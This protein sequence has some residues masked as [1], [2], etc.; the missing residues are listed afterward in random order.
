MSDINKR[1]ISLISLCLCLLINYCLADQAEPD[2]E[3]RAQ[4]VAAINSTDGFSD[5]FE[6][7]V[8]LV[9]MAKRLGSRIPDGKKRLALLKLVHNEATKAD[10]PPEL[11]LAVIEV[12]SNFDQWAI[13]KTGAQGLMQVMPF[14]LKE[15]G[16]PEDNLFRPKTNLRLGCTI[17]R[18]Y[19][20][21]EDGDLPRALARYNGSLGKTSYSDKVLNALQERWFRQ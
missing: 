7:E 12:E 21:K 10:L 20:S 9:D 16:H 8:W 17:L 13:S 1:V 11:V 18:Y 2:P 5:R 3:L 15:I 4:L 6:A 19:M 14:W